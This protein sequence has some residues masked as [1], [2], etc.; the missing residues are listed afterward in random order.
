VSSVLKGWLGWKRIAMSELKSC[1]LLRG[2]VR[3]SWVGMI[4]ACIHVQVGA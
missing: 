3:I 4:V 1:S 2:I